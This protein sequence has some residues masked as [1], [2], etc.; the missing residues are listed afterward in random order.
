MAL[1]V[2]LF[3]SGCLSSGQAAMLANIPRATFLL[4]CSRWGVASVQ[5]NET[6]IEMECI[7]LKKQNML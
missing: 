6:E 2:K 4:E 1:A 3:D 5:W 7:V